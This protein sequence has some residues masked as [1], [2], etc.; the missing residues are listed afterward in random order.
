MTKAEVLKYCAEKAEEGYMTHLMLLEIYN[1]TE[2]IPD[3]MVDLICHLPEPPKPFIMFGS[4]EMIKRFEQA[5]KDYFKA[6]V[7]HEIGEK[8]MDKI[9]KS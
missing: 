9:S 7:Q 1:D 8:L 4:F 3:D 2:E 5:Q 6:V